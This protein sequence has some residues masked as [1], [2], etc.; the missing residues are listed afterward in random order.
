MVFHTTLDMDMK[1][2][3]WFVGADIE[4]KH[5]NDE[6]ASYQE[7]I[8]Q[9]L[10]ATFTSAVNMAEGIDGGRVSYD[11]LKNIADAMRIML[12]ATMWLMRMSGDDL[13][14]HYDAWFFIQLTAKPMLV[15]SMHRS[16]DARRHILQAA[17]VVTDKLA[18]LPMTLVDPPFYIPDWA[19]CGITF[20]NDTT[21]PSPMDAKKLGWLG[22]GP[23]DEEEEH[24]A[25]EEADAG[26]L[27]KRPWHPSLT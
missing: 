18:K 14:A 7:A 10:V 3:V 27:M 12:A 13:L 8:L 2:P 6:L 16:F 24:K 9:R 21:L 4:D 25:D 5:E 23:S 11:W 15:A 1:L 22:T 17:T 26:G 19:S 20:S